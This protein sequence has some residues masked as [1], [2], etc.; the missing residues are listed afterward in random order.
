MLLGRVGN[1]D[2]LVLLLLLGGRRDPKRGGGRSRRGHRD[3]FR[4]EEAA[5]VEASRAC[6]DAACRA[7]RMQICRDLIK[8]G[9]DG[10]RARRVAKGWATTR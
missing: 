10:R 7:P 1:I 9:T 3:G 8:Q 4:T 2:A 5:A 6:T